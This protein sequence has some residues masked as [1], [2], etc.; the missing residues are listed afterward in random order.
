VYEE[1]TV[2]NL[3]AT[4][5]SPI[6][7]ALFMQ[8][9]CDG[10]CG[11]SVLA[12]PTDPV[13][14]TITVNE[15]TT[16]TATF[17]TSYQITLR[18]PG[19]G[20]GTVSHDNSVVFVDQHLDPGQAVPIL[21]E[22]DPFFGANRNFNLV[23]ADPTCV[24]VGWGGA[25]EVPWWPTAPP[26]DWYLDPVT[27]GEI[28]EATFSQTYEISIDDPSV[29]EGGTTQFTVTVTPE[30]AAG[31]EVRVTYITVDD[32]AIA[33]GDYTAH[34][35]TEL[36]FGPTESTKTINV[37][38]LADSL[39]ESQERF[40]VNLSA[41][42]ANATITDDQGEGFINDDGDTVAISISNATA[43]TEGGLATF[44]VSLDQDVP[45]GQSVTVQWATADDTATQPGDYDQV[46]P[47]TLTF[48]A[49]EGLAGKTVQV[50]TR[51]DPLAENQERFLVNLSSPSPNATIADAQGEGLIDDDL[52][53][54][55]IYIQSVT[56]FPATEGTDNTVTFTLALL[57]I[58]PTHGIIGAIQA[59]YATGG[60]NATPGSDYLSVIG[61]VTFASRSR[62]MPT[63]MTSLFKAWRL[64]LQK[65]G[66]TTRW[67]LPWRLQMWTPPMASLAPCR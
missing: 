14:A 60:G 47:T 17:L 62:M 45:T 58:D 28:V 48:N 67:H 12:N 5:T 23:S 27:G 19:T 39:Y 30:V 49:G 41:P 20:S 32:T 3:T 29:T 26:P 16:L 42:T 7:G 10:G 24:F 35:S 36:I 50:Q 21:V 54:Y 25:G 53:T 57:N 55:D 22:L 40:F 46:L 34:P 13:N 18:N 38:T 1:G 43:V 44:T 37:A 65:R 63:H 4:D 61:Q 15:D 8:W 33:A 52:D 9:A 51:D 56:P 64:P 66:Q 6:A 2:V 59:D 31:D 11:A